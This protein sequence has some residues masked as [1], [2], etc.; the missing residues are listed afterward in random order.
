MIFR[1][2][3]FTVLCHIDLLAFRSYVILTFVPM[4]FRTFDF[5]I[6]RHFDFTIFGHLI[7]SHFNLWTIRTSTFGILDF[8]VLCRFDLRTFRS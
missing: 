1:T 7:K 8:S 6:V 5:F 3:D 4:S 2:L